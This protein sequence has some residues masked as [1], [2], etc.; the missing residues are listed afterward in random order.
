[1][2]GKIIGIWGAVLLMI[3]MTVLVVAIVWLMIEAFRGN[4]EWLYD[5]VASR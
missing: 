4:K 5:K 3:L 1:M 2:I